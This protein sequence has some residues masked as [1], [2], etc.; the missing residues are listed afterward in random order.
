MASSGIGFEIVKQLEN[1]TNGIDEIWAIARRENLLEELK[2]KTNIP[3]RAIP[4][5]LT[6]VNSLNV[7]ENMLVTEQKDVGVLINC[8]GYGKFG[9]F[10]D[11]ENSA[12]LGMI[13]LNCRALVGVTNITLPFMKRGRKAALGI[14]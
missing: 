9:S 8:A 6:D 7:L 10:E 4:L 11:I 13:D 2:S 3:L 14:P 5:D 12:A 1:Y